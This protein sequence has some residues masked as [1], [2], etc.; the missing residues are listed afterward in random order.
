MDSQLQYNISELVQ[1]M[2]QCNDSNVVTSYS[3]LN[4]VNSPTAFNYTAQYELESKSGNEQQKS[5]RQESNAQHFSAMSFLS[6]T[7]Q[8]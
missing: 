5:V 8:P 3:G 6:I 7:Y 2:D 1:F 4:H